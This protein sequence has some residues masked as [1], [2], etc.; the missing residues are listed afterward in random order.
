MAFHDLF[1]A[2]KKYAVKASDNSTAFTEG[3]SL[4]SDID[5]STAAKTLAEGSIAIFDEN[6]E[7]IASAASTRIAKTAT[8]T[9]A[10]GRGFVD[11]VGVPP[12]VTS[13]IPKNAII[14]YKTFV[15]ATNCQ[16][17]LGSY[18]GTNGSLNL[19]A[20]LNEGDQ[21]TIQLMLTERLTE[22]IPVTYTYDTLV[23]NGDSATAILTRLVNKINLEE[24]FDITASIVSTDKGIKLISDE[25]FAIG[26]SGVFDWSDVI[27]GNSTI[28]G[29]TA[30]FA[31]EGQN[32]I[33]D[34]KDLYKTSTV[35]YGD[36]DG[37]TA[38]QW[39]VWKESDKFT[40]PDAEYNVISFAFDLTP[41]SIGEAIRR[42]QMP[43]L[44][45]AAEEGTGAD[46]NTGN[47]TV[48][49]DPILTAIFNDG[50]IL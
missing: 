21:A 32:S 17:F 41:P 49:I 26:A 20:T 9:L 24:K 10:C 12:F 38:K 31:T 23:R 28:S 50:D 6:N 22:N 27:D 33:Q 44:Y 40:N 25:N 2:N 39:S 3:D 13:A 34:L 47:M 18:D 7:L 46:A 5:G 4:F 42:V 14:N 48:I 11:G 35:D 19:P 43:S 29:H 36:T 37:M 1:I 30:T 45:I 8:V 15:A 16:A